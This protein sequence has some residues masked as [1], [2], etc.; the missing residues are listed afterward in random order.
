MSDFNARMGALGLRV[1]LWP[2]IH[3]LEMLAR[4]AEAPVTTA[5]RVLHPL[6]RLSGAVARSAERLPL[7]AQALRQ[8]LDTVTD[9]VLEIALDGQSDAAEI[10]RGMQQR[11]KT[12][13]LKAETVGELRDLR[14]ETAALG[15]D[16]AKFAERVRH[17]FDIAAAALPIYGVLHIPA[18]ENRDRADEAT[19]LATR[20]DALLRRAGARPIFERI[21]LHAGRGHGLQ[22]VALATADAQVA[23]SAGTPGI[24]RSAAA[25]TRLAATLA[26]LDRALDTALTAVTQ[27]MRYEAWRLKEEEEARLQPLVERLNAGNPCR[28]GRLVGEI[29]EGRAALAKHAPLPGLERL[30]APR[31]VT[32]PASPQRRATLS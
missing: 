4:R 31:A 32:A 8:R 22:T 18:T 5:E 12:L 26:P 6:R 24:D 20:A 23:A 7:A 29:L 16:I 30:A 14:R 11:Y 3:E 19:A 28:A 1:E 17:R 2:Q 27:T 9:Q 13:R 21:E 10:R 15:T 25:L